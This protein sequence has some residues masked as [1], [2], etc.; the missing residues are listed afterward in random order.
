M[1]LVV[2]V[3]SARLAVD[4]AAATR[5]EARIRRTSRN[6]NVAT[7]GNNGA[8]VWNDETSLEEAGHH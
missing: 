6:T 5:R 7:V 2:A 3:F 1:N 8:N 4:S